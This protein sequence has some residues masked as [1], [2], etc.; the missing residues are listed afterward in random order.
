MK[1]IFKLLAL[2]IILSIIKEFNDQ[3]KNP[4]TCTLGI[5]F[6]SLHKCF[7]LNYLLKAILIIIHSC[8]IV[9]TYSILCIKPK[10]MHFFINLNFLNCFI[11]H[12][13]F[14]AS[15]SFLTFLLL[16]GIIYVYKVNKSGRKGGYHENTDFPLRPYYFGTD[17]SNFD[18]SFTFCFYF[19]AK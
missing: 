18:S 6:V 15:C 3:T 13:A 19:F 9:N 1:K 2:I 5:F 7:S 16:F 10:N 12:C 11:S 8:I 14:S 4:Q 17:F